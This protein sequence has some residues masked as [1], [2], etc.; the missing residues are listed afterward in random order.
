[1][2]LDHM[3]KQHM[4][5]FTI[6]FE[7]YG[8]TVLHL[9]AEIGNEDLVRQLLQTPGLDVNAR[10]PR[11]GKGGCTALHNAALYGHCN[12]VS[13]LLQMPGICVNV[14][15]SNDNNPLDYAIMGGSLE[16]VRLLLQVPEIDVNNMSEVSTLIGA[17]SYW[18]HEEHGDHGEHGE[19]GEHG[20]QSCGHERKVRE[21][22]LSLLICDERTDL[23]DLLDDRQ[24]CNRILRTLARNRITFVENTTATTSN[25]R[26]RMGP[27]DQ[28]ICDKHEK[29]QIQVFTLSF[30]EYGSAKCNEDL[31]HLAAE[32]GNED[33]VRQL[34]QTPGL[35]VNA[36]DLRYG[37]GGCTALHHAA[38]QGHCNVVSMLLQMPGIC[39]NVTDS[40]DNNPLDCAVMG[41]S[42]E[43]VRLLLQVPE[44][45]VN[46][47]SDVST[48][49]GAISHITYQ[50][51][52]E[53]E[54]KEEILSLLICDERT[55]LNDLLD[56]QDTCHMLL[57]TL[58]R[59]RRMFVENTTT[60]NKRR[61]V[62][63][64]I[65]AEPME[66]QMLA[67]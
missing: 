63:P 60:S 18:Y 5:M 22:I 42:L 20:H 36:R 17:I 23:N 11:Y 40:D 38:Y 32:K 24:M 21:E 26:R 3:D 59:N 67:C 55:D 10:D 66:V 46:N 16:V 35:D 33:L 61:R 27:R 57:R 31:L 56:D 64:Q 28:Q 45:D 62:G 6:S 41:G 25:K 58:A 1:M 4:P 43:V 49:I 48:L 15:D 47:M 29:Q 19:H 37:Y 30:E 9:A 13:M 51:N 2:F 44:I 53:R 12:V 54:A 8:S 39:V 52:H 34:L 7:E 65:D 50:G 14:T